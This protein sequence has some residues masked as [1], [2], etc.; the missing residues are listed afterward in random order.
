MDLES[1][2]EKY[3]IKPSDQEATNITFNLSPGNITAIINNETIPGKFVL[4]KNT[5]GDKDGKF[6]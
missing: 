6:Y 5:Y 1:I 2:D 4:E 3:W